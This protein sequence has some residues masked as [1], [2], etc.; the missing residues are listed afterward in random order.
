MAILFI[1][2]DG[3]SK[4]QEACRLGLGHLL[5]LC[6]SVCLYRRQPLFQM[7]HLLVSP[8]S[9]QALWALRHMVRWIS[10]CKCRSTPYTV[11]LRPCVRSKSTNYLALSIWTPLL[12]RFLVHPHHKWSPIRTCTHAFSSHGA[13]SPISWH[14]WRR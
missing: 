10:E 2:K 3:F 11:C 13:R 8:A 1:R 9:N 4:V 6:K 7:I 5:P 14:Q 12:H